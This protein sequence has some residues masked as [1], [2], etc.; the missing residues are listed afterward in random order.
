MFS[1]DKKMKFQVLSLE[2]YRSHVSN[3]A[4][5]ND[6]ISFLKPLHSCK[7]NKLIFAHINL[8]STRNKF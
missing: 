6:C 7:S 2:E 4:Q 5:A 8:N 1:I 3:V